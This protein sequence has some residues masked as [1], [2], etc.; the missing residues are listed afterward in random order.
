M[1]QDPCRPFQT[2]ELEVKPIVVDEVEYYYAPS[3]TSVFGVSIYEY[4]KVI[5]GYTRIEESDDRFEKILD[6]LDRNIK[7][8]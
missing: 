8:Q 6:A 5:N 2:T 7:T 1:A 3:T 4:D